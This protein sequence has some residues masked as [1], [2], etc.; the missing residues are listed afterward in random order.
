LNGQSLTKA[1]Y[2]SGLFVFPEDARRWSRQQRD[3]TPQIQMRRCRQLQAQ[4]NLSRPDAKQCPILHR[5]VRKN[6][7]E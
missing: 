2:V 3:F 6:S 4:E 7:F 5:S 1:R